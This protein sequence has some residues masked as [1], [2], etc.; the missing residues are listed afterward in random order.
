MS[1]AGARPTAADAGPESAG[2]ARVAAG[3][4]A[5][6]PATVGDL[7]RALLALFPAADAE[8]WDRTGLLVGDPD[9][10]VRRVAVALDPTVSAI[11][12]A[13]EAGADVLL[14]HHPAFLRAPDD[15][16]PAASVAAHS[17]AGVFEAVRLGVALVCFHTA[18]DVSEPAQRM[19][20]GLLGLSFRRVLVPVDAAGLKGYGQLCT[21]GAGEGEAL[22]LRGLAL[23]ARESLGREPRVWGEP[24]RRLAEVVTCTGAVGDVARAALAAG[25]DCVLCGEVKYHEALDVSQAGLAVVEVGHDGSE[26]PFCG[27]LADQ[28]L[29][30]GYDTG[31]VVVLPQ[32]PNWT[33]VR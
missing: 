9:A 22:T 3:G 27:L 30:L 14:T 26:L 1:G 21:A 33:T 23:R 18:L 4:A 19:L 15:F 11:R 32:A 5:A 2:A 31:Q 12:A 16:L 25:A 29:G 8:E 20:P 10:P 7:E 6:C 17:G 24:D 13:S 28:L